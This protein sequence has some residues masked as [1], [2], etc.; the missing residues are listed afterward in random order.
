MAEKKPLPMPE[1]MT[2]KEMDAMRVNE[3]EW[4]KSDKFVCCTCGEPAYLHPYTNH[5]WGCKKCGFTT[6]SVAMYFHPVN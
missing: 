4:R 3:G 1:G 5:I 6:Y 2:K